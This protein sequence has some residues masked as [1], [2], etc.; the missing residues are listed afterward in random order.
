MSLN[1]EH[2]EREGKGENLGGAVAPTAIQE[3]IRAPDALE[4]S[5]TN[6]YTYNIHI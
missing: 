3:T 1:G 5:Y 2:H 4:S 6:T